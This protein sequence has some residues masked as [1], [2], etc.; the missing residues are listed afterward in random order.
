MA[1]LI[2]DAIRWWERALPERTAVVCEGETVSYAELGSWTDSVAR[3]LLTDAGVAPGDVVGIA[4]FNSLNWVVAALGAVKAG[5]IL[6]PFNYRYTS[7]ELRQLVEDATPVLVFA[8]D[9]QAGKLRPTDYEPAP[10]TL[11]AMSEVGRHRADTPGPLTVERSPD[12]AVVLAYTSGTTGRPKGLVYTHETVLSALF[13][14]MLKDPTPPEHTCMLLALPLFSVAGIVHAVLHMAARGATLV[15]MG[16]FE[17]SAALGLLARHQVSHLNGVP[18]IWERMAREPT[19]DLLDL[20]HIKVAMVGGARVSNELQLRW[21]ER[22][23]V[24]RHMYGMTEV[25]GCV[26]VPRPTDA[27]ARPDLCGDGSVFTEI[28][29]ARPDGSDC[30]PGEEGEILMRGPAMLKEYWRN[31]EGTAA[32]VPD[33]WIHSGDVGLMDESGYLR[34]VDR[35]KDLIISGGFNVSPTEVE[36]VIARAPGVIEVAVIPIVDEQW[37]ETP[38]AIIHGTEDLDVDEVLALARLELAV[39]KVPRYVV[40]HD[41]PLPRMSSQK[42]AKHDLCDQYRDIASKAVRH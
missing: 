13:E 38:A 7:S 24:L 1:K 29:V 33:G 4:G 10:F 36:E 39:F 19:F 3:W 41:G 32:L 25:G 27:V 30:R 26:S 14:L 17:P 40:H 9:E 12:D 8:D 22:G 35:L 23:V 34:Y 31:P 42:I 37:G 5:A 6:A 21:H 15:V 18:V 2:T 28:R 20:S 11:V 16:D